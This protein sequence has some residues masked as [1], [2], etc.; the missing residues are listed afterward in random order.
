MIH[1]DI[2][3]LSTTTDAGSGLNYAEYSMISRVE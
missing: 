1:L 2:D 3:R